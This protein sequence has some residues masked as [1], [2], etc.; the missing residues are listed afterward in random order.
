[1]S[2]QIQAAWRHVQLP[3]LVALIAGKHRSAELPC[4]T[5][6]IGMTVFQVD[7]VNFSVAALLKEKYAKF[8][9]ILNAMPGGIP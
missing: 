5:I 6:F 4:M 7:G 1:M 9:V 8:Q 2:T 3:L